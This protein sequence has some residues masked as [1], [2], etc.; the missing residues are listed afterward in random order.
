MKV[1]QLLTCLLILWGS[2]AAHAYDFEL[3]GVYYNITDADSKTVEVTYV[4]NGEGNADFYYGTI[5]IPNRIS[6]DG[7]TY[8]VTAIGD[9]AFHYCANLTSVTL[10]NN[11][12]RIDSRAFDGCT[13]LTEIVIPNSVTRIEK[14]AFSGCSSLASVT[15]PSQL[16]SMDNAAFQLCTSLTSIAIPESVTTIGAH[17]FQN[18]SKLA[19][20]NI[21]E[22]V[23][24]INEYLFCGCEALTSIEIP[25]GVTRSVGI[26]PKWVDF[27]GDTGRRYHNRQ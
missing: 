12:T 17:A 23:T 11:V 20:V 27:C 14:E 3:N 19:S 8:L 24:V 6:K 18:C 22:G 4:E 2:I 5:T 9:D 16:V 21:P 25:S 10:G 15:L 13:G 1:K 7:V 26:Q